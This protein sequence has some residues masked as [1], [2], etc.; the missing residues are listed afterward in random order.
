[1]KSSAHVDWISF[2]L[3]GSG[4]P[5]YRKAARA[6]SFDLARKLWREGIVSLDTPFDK[7]GFGLRK[8]GRFPKVWEPEP[9]DVRDDSDIH[10]P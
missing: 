10:L 4:R 2:N 9:K 1:M 3:L 6:A 7:H 5:K 8:F